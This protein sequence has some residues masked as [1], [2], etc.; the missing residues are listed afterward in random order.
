LNSYFYRVSIPYWISK[1]FNRRK[2]M[3]LSI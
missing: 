3:R 1:K 2:I